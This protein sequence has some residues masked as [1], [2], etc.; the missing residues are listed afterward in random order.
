MLVARHG[1]TSTSVAVSN[2]VRPAF[3]LRRIASTERAGATDA[4]RS[5]R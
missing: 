5:S 2:L 3:A 4:G 1:L